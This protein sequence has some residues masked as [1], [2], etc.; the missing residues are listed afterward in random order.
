MIFYLCNGTQLAPTQADAR[1]IDR[2]FTQIDVPVDKQGLMAFVNNLYAQIWAKE[3]TFD[4][5][6]R[7]LGDQ[8]PVPGPADG[9]DPEPGVDVAVVETRPPQAL[10]YTERSILTN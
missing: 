10:S 4:D 9:S 6:Y 8:A 7:P 3:D 5:T 2:D 1:A